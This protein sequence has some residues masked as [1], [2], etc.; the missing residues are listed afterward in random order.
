MNDDIIEALYVLAPTECSAII[1]LLG[2]FDNLYGEKIIRDPNYDWVGIEGFER[3]FNHCLRCAEGFF[4][5]YT[6]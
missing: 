3:C 6:F 2:D 4:E 5:K 1:K